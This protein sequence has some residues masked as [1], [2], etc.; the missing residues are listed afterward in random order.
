MFWR[1]SWHICVYRC[2]CVC[3]WI[4]T[5]IFMQRYM[6]DEENCVLTPKISWQPHKRTVNLHPSIITKRYFLSQCNDQ[7]VYSY[8]SCHSI[9]F[10]LLFLWT[11][12]IGYCSKR[13]EKR[14]KN[15]QIILIYVHHTRVS[16]LF[17]FGNRIRFLIDGDLMVLQQK[18][19]IYI[20][21]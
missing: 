1:I 19:S 10:L 12:R 9:L 15:N 17:T 5:Y 2:V 3:V 7:F 14:K 11:L 20:S 21:I 13:K 6:S 18:F 16:N 8:F 4:K